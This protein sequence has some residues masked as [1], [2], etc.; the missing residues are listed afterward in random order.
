MGFNLQLISLA[1]LH[2]TATMTAQLAQSF[3][4]EGMLGYVRRIQAVEKAIGCDVLRHQQWSGSE[5]IDGI[6]SAVAAGSLATAAT[7][8]E[9]TEKSFASS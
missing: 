4:E 9:S 1:G 6:L 2:S 8:A 7:G 5:Y 3:K